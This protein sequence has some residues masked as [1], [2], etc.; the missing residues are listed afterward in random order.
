MTEAPDRLGNL[1]W[2]SRLSRFAIPLNLSWLTDRGDGII[3]P[4]KQHQAISK[5]SCAGVPDAFETRIARGIS[6]ESRD[7][8]L[9]LPRSFTRLSEVR[10]DVAQASSQIGRLVVQLPLV[11]M[12]SKV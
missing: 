3:F 5:E 8:V 11:K 2:Q 7:K 1:E 9:R 6:D 4:V 10:P 12:T